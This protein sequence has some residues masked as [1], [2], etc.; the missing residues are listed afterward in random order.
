M[1]ETFREDRAAPDGLQA[2]LLLSER[3]ELIKMIGEG[4]YGQVWSAT[5][6]LNPHHH[7]AI[8]IVRTDVRQDLA[9]QQFQDECSAL[10]L[11]LRS[12]HIVK[13][14]GRGVFRGRDYLVMERL[15]GQALSA[16][17]QQEPE[18]APTEWKS[19][20]AIITQV[21]DAV[22]AA[23]RLSTPGP[24]IHRD[25]KPENI[26]LHT[27]ADGQ[28]RATLFDF[29]VAQLGLRSEAQPSQGAIGTVPYMAPE[30]LLN[31]PGS[32]GPWT[33]VFALGVL[34]VELL[35]RRP[36]GPEGCH[37][38]TLAGA[39]RR[40]LGEYL[41]KCRPELSPAIW[42]IIQRALAHQPE[43]RYKDAGALRAALQHVA[44]SS[45]SLPLL[46]AESLTRSLDRLRQHRFMALSAALSLLVPVSVGMVR[47]MDRPQAPAVSRVPTPAAAASTLRGVPDPGRSAE[48]RP[49]PPEPPSTTEMLHIAGGSFRMGSSYVEAMAAFH[50]CITLFGN[51][52]CAE[53]SFL[54]ESPARLVQVDS[55]WMDRT[56]V[57][58]RQLAAWLN[59]LRG[60]GIKTEPEDP[61]HAPRY[62]TQGGT[63]LL[64][65]YPSLSGAPSLVLKNGAFHPRPGSEELPA[66]VVSWDLARSYCTAFG[67]RLPTEAEW[68]YAARGSENRT[69]PWGEAQPQC[70]GVTV[71][72]GPRFCPGLTD[73]VKPV[74]TSPQ[75]QTPEGVHDLGGNVSE[76]IEDMYRP[77]YA[78]CA[79][80]R[81]QNPVVLPSRRRAGLTR[82][83][84]GGNWS[85]SPAV[86]RAAARSH[87]APDFPMLNTGFRCASAVRI[88]PVPLGL[89]SAPDSEG[90]DKGRDKGRDRWIGKVP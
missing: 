38:R 25:I 12:S 57:T 85:W 50:F 40:Q 68:E 29:G 59:T 6:L 14:L 56:E 89:L 75:D 5:D 62:V 18:G 30:Q 87:A 52:D 46:A 67:K 90:R 9:R 70:G 82:V 83:I 13:I 78:S 15:E 1:A 63:V 8:K 27:D 3:Y 55:F 4:A 76:W 7:V 65:L 86:S 42:R 16:W 61:M 51:D 64:D 31:K 37:L 44:P 41:K 74:G 24:I 20:Y 54:R 32:V 66:V 77:S 73:Q 88:A 80:G 71:R 48:E 21:C 47:L 11:L 35:T 22:A 2:G 39:Q 34:L 53:E 84:R 81:C 26:M 49:A 60:L 43:D 23:H 45:P 69:Y 19:V 10:E 58:N 28:L 17:L 36:Y 72:S 33:D 79:S